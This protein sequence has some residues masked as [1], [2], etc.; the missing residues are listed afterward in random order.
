MGEDTTSA[1]AS[2][3]MDLTGGAADEAA[4][5][6]NSM[7]TGGNGTLENRATV[8]GRATT[9]NTTCVAPTST[10]RKRSTLRS[11]V[12]FLFFCFL[13]GKGIKSISVGEISAHST[14]T[15]VVYVK[16]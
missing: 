9:P 11:S 12:F 8:R 10:V 4:S 5:E 3:S 15:H 1:A 13:L 14:T 16:E 2:S 6:A 7:A